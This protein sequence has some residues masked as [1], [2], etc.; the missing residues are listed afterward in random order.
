MKIIKKLS[1]LLATVLILSL[2]GVAAAKEKLRVGHDL[3]IGFSGVFLAQELG[4]FSDAGLEVDMRGFPGPGDS[5]PPVLAG[6]LDITLTTLHNL[7]LI[8]GTDNAELAAVYFLDSSHGADAIVARSGI[9]SVADL[10]GRDVAVTLN[11]ANHMLLILALESAGM[12][13]EDVRLV[14]MSADDAGAALLAGRVD[15]AVT[16]EP[17]VSRARSGGDGHVIFSTRDAPDTI[18]NTITVRRDSLEKRPEALKAFIQAVDR[19]VAYLRSNPEQAIPIIARWL[20]ADEADVSGMLEDDEI[21]NIAENSALFE[22]E[23]A[24]GMQAL[25]TVIGFL[26]DRDLIQRRP[27][28]EELTDDRFVR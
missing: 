4:Y 11:E 25:E 23:S 15:A 24:S 10:R 17:W 1:Y 20:E 3:W 12:S 28:V 21:Y 27:T 13:E 18:L 22:S 19:G 26:H 14:N 9:D 8:A 2:P 5:I 6:H 16:W 7:A